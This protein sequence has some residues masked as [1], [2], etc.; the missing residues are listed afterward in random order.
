MA[1]REVALNRMW[2][3][4]L[5]AVWGMGSAGALQAQ[6]SAATLPVEADRLRVPSSALVVAGAARAERVAPVALARRAAGPLEQAQELL[7]Q[8]RLAEALDR[9]QMARRFAPGHPLVEMMAARIQLRSGNLAEAIRSGRLASERGGEGLLLSYLEA[10][11]QLLGG[12]R[13]EALRELGH[14]L[15]GARSAEPAEEPIL[16]ALSWW[17]FAELA[18]QEG[19]TLAAYEALEKLLELGGSLPVNTPAELAS[20]TTQRGAAV[21][22][23]A[24]R[25]ALVLED[26]ASAERL[27]EAAIAQGPMTEGAVA[28]RLELQA[29]SGD[30]AGAMKS[31]VMLVL[32][33]AQEAGSGAS[34]VRAIRALG[35]LD[36]V[37]EGWLQEERIAADPQRAVQA[38]A[39]LVRGVGEK[40]LAASILL[41]AAKKAPLTLDS[42]W[43]LAQLAAGE[44]GGGP[45]A[46]WSVLGDLVKANPGVLPD[47]YVRLVGE[48]R[49]GRLVR[50][51]THEGEAE[52]ALLAGVAALAAQ[53]PAGAMQAAERAGAG[54]WSAWMLAEAS[55]QQGSWEAA[56]KQVEG[57]REA[58]AGGALSATVV[59]LIEARAMVGLGRVEE[60]LR[61]LSERL[62]FDAEHLELRLLH[63]DL[64]QQ[65]GQLIRAQRSYQTILRQ[66]PR[67]LSILERLAF[68]LLPERAMEGAGRSREVWER[69]RA[70]DEEASATVRVG[71]VTR[72]INLMANARGMDAVDAR[73]VERSF[74][75]SLRPVANR[76]TDTPSER[77]RTTE[78]LV[79]SHLRMFDPVGA[80]ALCEP[81]LGGGGVGGEG[82]ANVRLLSAIS[83]MK[84]GQFG[85]AEALLR[86]LL[87]SHPAEV[88]IR[89]ALGECLLGQEQFEAGRALLL[90]G[91]EQAGLSRLREESAF[92]EVRDEQARRAVELIVRSHFI[93]RQPQAAFAQVRAWQQAWN[94]DVNSVRL[95][96]PAWERLLEYAV[97]GGEAK[98]ALAWLGEAPEA[99]R[100]G[101]FGRYREAQWRMRA[102]EWAAA[103]RLLGELMAEAGE[104]REDRR[105]V[106]LRMQMML[107]RIVCM[108]NLGRFDDALEL[109][110]ATT[111]VASTEEW[112][113]QA[114]AADSF[115]ELFSVP[116]VMSVE[117]AVLHM[118]GDLAGAVR[119]VEFWLGTLENADAVE[120]LYSG[121]EGL[122]DFIR[123]NALQNRVFLY[124]QAQDWGAAL[125]AADKLSEDRQRSIIRYLLLQ[126]SGRADE[127]E[128]IEED[129]LAGAR[130]EGD[131]R[132]IALFCNN[133]GYSWCNRNH[134][135]DEARGLIDE[136]LEKGLVPLPWR[137]A[138][139]DGLLGQRNDSILRNDAPIDSMAWA[140]YKLERYHE[141]FF[142]MERIA[143]VPV[144]TRNA[145]AINYLH[146]GDIQWKL[147]MKAHARWSWTMG[148]SQFQNPVWLQHHLFPGSTA[149]LESI[150]AVR[151]MGE[152]LAAVEKGEEPVVSPVGELSRAR[153]KTQPAKGAEEPSEPAATQATEGQ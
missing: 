151:K 90:E 109:L 117:P 44:T 94:T 143:G 60:A 50:E 95:R 137:N 74:Q 73:E 51:A 140:F 81:L 38:L 16:V 146:L 5:V 41:A 83:H 70:I 10:Q 78:L 8:E 85:A 111:K 86:G 136:A 80:L 29:G 27:L 59:S 12:R 57:L 142:W 98:L 150:H 23:R 69:M 100:E 47:L 123:T 132:E 25:L 37:L 32:E 93:Q 3:T 17:L 7:L 130:R 92:F 148:R 102:G 9:V 138:G 76:E 103:D 82:S 35:P 110:H 128:G 149:D 112:L 63:A 54:T 134:R 2:L 141:A 34:A 49:I 30:R 115:E 21:R 114:L 153:P 129:L 4:A 48:R 68:A 118:K 56:L 39:E 13:A 97:E 20:L 119:V 26:S 108:V 1:G 79:M 42:A 6:P 61:L 88:G 22:V 126:E 127:A 33:H 145:G 65:T 28:L 87:A 89:F 139:V 66:N 14:G 18:E 124:R 147:G 84:L 45:G 53:D 116:M 107:G 46:V 135:L 113:K 133:L 62:R 99:L 71:A 152:R 75:T 77:S 43:Q 55:V 67:D 106:G 101:V 91:L 19:Y 31:L 105:E 72:L 40:D 131:V 104:Q 121:N 58:A 144:L 24:A 96:T 15:H 120:K 125:E 36:D 122:M 64:C 11:S 52:P